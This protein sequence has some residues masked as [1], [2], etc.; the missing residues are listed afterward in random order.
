MCLSILDEDKDWK[1]SIT[2]KQ[3]LLGV[4]DLLDNPNVNDPAQNDAYVLFVK[5]TEEYR[6]RVAQQSREYIPS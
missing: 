2:V 4:Q 5:N 6:K 1:P 3:I